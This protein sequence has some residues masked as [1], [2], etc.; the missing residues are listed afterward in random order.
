MAIGK[1]DLLER[2]VNGLVGTTEGKFVSCVVTNERGLIVAKKS[3]NGLSNQP[4]AAMVSL[5]SDTA[6]RINDNMG[7]E[8]PKTSSISSHGVLISTYEFLVKERWFRIGVV[9]TDENRGRRRLF[10]RRID[11]EKVN[12]FLGQ[13]A[14]QIRN[15]LEGRQYS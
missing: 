1:Y 5:L 12:R 11:Y 13:A 6:C 8:H 14:V 10:R 3:V 4:L 9:L 2:I 7:Y 15:I